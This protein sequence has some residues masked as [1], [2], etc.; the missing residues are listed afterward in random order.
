M[1][2]KSNTKSAKSV[3]NVSDEVVQPEEVFFELPYPPFSGNNMYDH[4]KAG[5]KRLKDAVVQY[6]S[7]V[8]GILYALGLAQLRLKGPRWV[9]WQISPRDNKRVDVDNFRKPVA[10]AITKA[11]VWEDDSNLVLPYEG[12]YWMPPT[13]GGR[14]RIWVR[15]LETQTSDTEVE[16]NQATQLE[17]LS[18]QVVSDVATGGAPW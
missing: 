16:D 7:K 18:A 9:E 14:V 17:A 3:G 12:F 6:R 8:H 1:A 2:Q 13:P 4:D 15:K 5:G 10:D 11:G